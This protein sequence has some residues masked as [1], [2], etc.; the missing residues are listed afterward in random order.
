MEPSQVTW[1]GTGNA[2]LGVDRGKDAPFLIY[3]IYLCCGVVK[4]LFRHVLLIPA[5]TNVAADECELGIETMFT[6]D[7]TKPNLQLSA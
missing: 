7:G 5:V 6:K 1:Q 2:D 3:N 4:R